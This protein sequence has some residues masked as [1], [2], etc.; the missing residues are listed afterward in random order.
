MNAVLAA[1][2][3]GL[4]GDEIDHLRERQS[5]H[6][7]V[8]ALAADREPAEHCAEKR[9]NRSAG[10]NAELWREAPDLDGVGGNI[11]GASEKSRMA[12]R[13]Q[14]DIADQQVEGARE[15]GEAEC[16]HQKDGVEE[17]GGNEGQHD[18]DHGQ[19]PL[20]PAAFRHLSALAQR[21]LPA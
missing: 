11:G 18:Q 6:R 21:N 5:D 20:A 3:A 1:C 19:D 10:E 7:K 15:K 9:C 2:E 12:E 17:K 16:L 13:Q 4:Q 14:T 8:D